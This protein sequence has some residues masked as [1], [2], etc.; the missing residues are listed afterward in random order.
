[1]NK[2]KD[3]MNKIQEL[4]QTQGITEKGG[5]KYTLVQDRVDVFR[6]YCEF[7][8]GI[9]TS[10]V[11]DDGK[12][13]VFKAVIK[14]LEGTI[15]GCG[16]AEEIRG[17][18]YVN[19]FSPVENCETSAIGRALSSCGLSGGEYASS[20]EM[21]I[22]KKKKKATEK[23]T[24]SQ[25]AGKMSG[26][27][28][29]LKEAIQQANTPEWTLSFPGGKKKTYIGPNVLIDDIDAMLDKIFES[30]N[31]RPDEKIQYIKDFFELNDTRIAYLRKINNDDTFSNIDE[32]IRRFENEN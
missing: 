7:N 11:I 16:Y 2:M 1:M 28:K 19:K 9:E 26:S 30:D 27:T 10:M 8:Y 5:K 14:D 12:R 17:Q 32:K 13:I 15:I 20:L 4:N 3:M 31:K 6:K 25:N 21:D 22:A 24:R 18:G 29:D 23:A